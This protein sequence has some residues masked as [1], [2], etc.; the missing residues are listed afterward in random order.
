MSLNPR[1]PAERNKFQK[2]RSSS[3]DRNASGNPSQP[4]GGT[5]GTDNKTPSPKSEAHAKAAVVRAL[6]AGT[7]E[8]TLHDA[9]LDSGASHVVL[10]FS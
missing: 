9:V 10:P 6:S 5:Q 7:N 3:R 2:S 4:R 8:G 1:H